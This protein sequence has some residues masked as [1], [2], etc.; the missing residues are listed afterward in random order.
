VRKKGDR[1]HSS[2]LSRSE[3]KPV[4]FF[5]QLCRALERD[6]AGSTARRLVLLGQPA[7]AAALTDHV[8]AQYFARWRGANAGVDDPNGEPRFVG[9]LSAAAGDARCFEPGWWVSQRLPGSCFVTDGTLHLHV[10]EALDLRR[11][12]LSLPCVRPAVLPHFFYWLSPRGRIRKDRPFVRIYLHIAAR[13]AP[14]LV[15]QLV[16]R[17]RFRFEAKVPNHPALFARADAAVIYV[18]PRDLPAALRIVH[19]LRRRH[20][21]AFLASTPLFTARLAPGVAIAES[22]AEPSPSFG[23]LRS[24]WV[25][26]TVARAAGRI[27]PERWPRAIARTFIRNGVDPARPFAARLSPRVL[28]H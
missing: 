17:A 18:E 8:Y 6:L 16:R 15:R 11:G 3:M 9:A 27:P 7:N 22:P 5:A 19:D 28:G 24:R 2:A 14:Q 10:T 23:E 12:R 25:A 20:P 21:R 26:A 1:L 4:P 13:L